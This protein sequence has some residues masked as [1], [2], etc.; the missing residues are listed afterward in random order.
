MTP[1]PDSTP[2]SQMSPGVSF[3]GM[4]VEPSMV[5]P[6]MD[7]SFCPRHMCDS[8]DLVEEVE[9]P[10]LGWEMLTV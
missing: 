8:G 7:P 5:G 1:V 10:G 4:R 2:A 6:R 9:G 3:S